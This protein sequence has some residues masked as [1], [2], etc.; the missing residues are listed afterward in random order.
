M[1][2]DGD[3]VVNPATD[4][5]LLTRISLGIKGSAA[6]AGALGASAT[7]TTWTQVR[8]YLFSECNMPVAP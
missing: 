3:G 8:D 1:D 4:G 6:L 5:L 7:R 2:I